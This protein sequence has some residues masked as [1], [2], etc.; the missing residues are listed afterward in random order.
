MCGITGYIGINLK[1]KSILKQM[2][3]VI[4]H[5]GP[6][7]EGHYYSRDFALGHRR[8]AILD[9]SEEASQPMHYLDRYIITYNGEIYNY[10]EIREELEES[11][12]R[13]HSESDTEVIL[14]AYAHW[15][16]NCLNKFNGDWAFVL[17]DK[18]TQQYFIARDRFGVKPLYYFCDTKKFIFGSEVKAIYASGLV[19]KAPNLAYLRQ[20][21]ASG[22]NEYDSATAFEN[23][24]RFPFAHYFHGTKEDLLHELKF[25][26]YWELKIDESNERFDPNKAKKYAAKYYQILS[27]SVRLRLRADVKVGGALSGGLD[28]ASIVYLINEHLKK[29]G[30][31]SQLECFST[32]YKSKDTADCDESAYIDLMANTLNLI[33]HK[34]EPKE[35]AI[36]NEY[37][38]MICAMET[39]PEST[40][41]SGWHT[42][43]LVKKSGVIVTLDGQGADEQLAGYIHYISSYLIS[44]SLADLYKE[45]FC[46]LR[47]P[48]A[49]KILFLSFLMANLK[50][51]FGEKLFQNFF[52]LLKNRAAPVCLNKTLKRS[53]ETGLVTLIHYSD[54]TCMAHS[55]ESRMPFMDYRLVEF[56]GSIPACYKIHNGWTKFIAR[57]AFDKKL[58]DDIC[59]RKDKMGWPSP[60]NKWYSGKLNKWMVKSAN[61]TKLLNE[62]K[63][64]KMQLRKFRGYLDVRILN[65]ASV[66]N[67]INTNFYRND[68]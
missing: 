33:S 52:F 60:E 15:G 51:L 62:L 29:K 23:I 66:E 47:I 35:E 26:R 24:Y 13:F 54:H 63:I 32:V 4:M 34:I 37:K 41:M 31:Q 18:K 28:S 11:G 20:Y 7:G 57:Q 53:F 36:P 8:L 1:D 19:K 14:A 6:D 42:S 30:K 46:L 64:K 25:H 67:L 55:L 22:P 56:L 48:G 10:I 27:D 9:L 43:M 45:F 61:K 39:P 65:I 49:R 38:K 17:Y 44:L 40:C 16:V 21:L 2:T 5:R 68:G 58:P 50:K 3:D 12:Y 59:W